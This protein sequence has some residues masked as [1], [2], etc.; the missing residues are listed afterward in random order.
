MGRKGRRNNIMKIYC[1]ENKKIR[2]EKM[3]LQLFKKFPRSIIF[4]FFQIFQGNKEILLFPY[5]VQLG[6]PVMLL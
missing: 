2:I 5:G 1:V 6:I 4:V 3:K